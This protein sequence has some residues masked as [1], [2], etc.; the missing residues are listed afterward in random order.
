MMVFRS[1]LA[2]VLAGALVLAPLAGAPVSAQVPQ[3]QATPFPAMTP[4]PVPTASGTPIPYPAYG[5][6]APDVAQQ[7]PKAGVPTTVSLQQAVDIAVMLSPA[8]ATQRAQY[9]AIFAKYGAEQGA[10]FPSLSAEGTITRTYGN[11]TTNGTSGTSTP[12]PGSLNNVITTENGHVSIEQLIFDGGQAIAAIRSAKEASVAGKDTLVRD[13]QTLAYNVATAYYNLLQDQATVV[14]DNSIVREDQTQEN[15][16]I[17]QIKTGAAAR[18]DLAAAQFATA[19]AKG[20]LVTAQGAVIAGQATFATTLG[21]DADAEVNPQVQSNQP[22]V[23]TLTY[24]QAVALALQI[25][26]DYLAA[27]HTVTSDFQNVRYAKLAR[28]PQITANGSTG[29]SRLLISNPPVASAWAPTG[30]LGATVN[31]PIYDQGLTNYN[32]AVAVSEYDQ[33]LANLTAT[34]QTVESNVRG[35]LAQLIS[36]RASFVQA[37]AELQSAQVAAQATSA[38]YRV[39]AASITDITTADANLATAQRDYVAAEYSELLYEANYDYAVGN[40]DLKL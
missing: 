23:K 9:N 31:L 27:E 16:V 36:A 8:F 25:R 26:P 11:G 7:A 6:P 15:Y 34:K 19:Q 22:P 30:Q 32:I 17:A 10:L 24:Q 40:S 38:R 35:A 14:A 33:A 2:R 29:T 18:S 4:L 3:T 28:M 21:L 5:T 37:Q 12:A 39:G 1:A 20:A 13:L